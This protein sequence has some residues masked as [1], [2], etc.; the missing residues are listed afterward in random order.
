MSLAAHFKACGPELLVAGTV[1]LA[2]KAET[3][4]NY[5]RSS[6]PGLAAQ[7]VPHLPGAESGFEMGKDT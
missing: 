2:V 6:R 4:H 7:A 5:K 1:L 3:V